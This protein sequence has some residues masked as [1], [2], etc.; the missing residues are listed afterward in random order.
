MALLV[1]RSGKEGAFAGRDRASTH[2]ASI[3][4]ITT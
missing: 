1:Q 3:E 2:A 4:I